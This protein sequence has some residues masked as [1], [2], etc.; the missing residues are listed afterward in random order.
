MLFLINCLLDLFEN[1]E[2]NPV[3]FF[4]Y[5]YQTYYF[6]FS[7]VGSEEKCASRF[8]LASLW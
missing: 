2:E 1:T 5:T 3:V 7:H 4:L 6:N 8:T